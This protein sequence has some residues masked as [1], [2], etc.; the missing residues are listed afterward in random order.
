M[1]FIEAPP[2][3]QD[4]G[5]A[6]LLGLDIPASATNSPSSTQS[7]DLYVRKDERGFGDDRDGR[8]P[9]RGNAHDDVGHR[10]RFRRR[11]RGAHAVPASNHKGSEVIHRCAIAI[12]VPILGATA[13]MVAR[14]AV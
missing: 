7:G 5:L 9:G 4:I 13:Y 14:M 2:S 3:S 12:A 8:P 1:D 6:V 10:G 11:P